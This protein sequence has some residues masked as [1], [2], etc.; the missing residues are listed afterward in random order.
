M[1]CAANIGQHDDV[2]LYFGLSGTGKTTLSTDPSRRLIG[3]DE[4]GWSDNGIFNF[5]G[6]CY[7]KVIRISKQQEPQIY[8][9][10]RRFGTILE[11]VTIDTRTRRL[12]LDD[13]TFTENTRACYPIPHIENAV[14]N[15]I[16][17]HPKNI[18][19]LSCDAFGVLPAIA[20]LTP[21]QAAYYFLQGYTARV[22]GTEIGVKEPE[23]VFSPC[24]GAPFMAL[25]PMKYARLLL[26]KI[27]QHD[28]Q[29]W[30]VNTG[31]IGSKAGN[32][33]RISLPSTRNLIRSAIE[34]DLRNVPM[35]NDPVFGFSVPQAVSDIPLELL[36]PLNAWENKAAYEEQ[37]RK[38]AQKFR[39]NFR[40]FSA[41]CP[42]EVLNCGPDIS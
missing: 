5:E 39:E 34:G 4:H 35:S 16:G 13:A 3:D 28:V 21:Q 1:H 17:H 15:G 23:A 36:K 24:F 7:A 41:D 2:A 40:Q 19:M 29:C 26:K 6:G 11:N 27:M 30:L 25:Q 14:R 8:E 31:W 37:V 42:A 38:L 33:D 12:N 18:F 20:R 10:T 22:A 9:C 32:S